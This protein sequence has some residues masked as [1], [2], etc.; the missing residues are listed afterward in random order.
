MADFPKQKE[1]RDSRL[2]FAKA[3]LILLVI[4]GHS[5][6]VLELENSRYFDLWIYKFIYSFHMPAFM[7]ISGY[8]FFQSNT[9][10]LKTVILTKIKS[11]GIPFLSFTCLM[12]FLG[13]I[14]DLFSLD[15]ITINSFPQLLEDLFDYILTSKVMWF[16]ASILINS[17]IASCLSRLKVGYVGFI[18]IIII[19][20]FIPVENPY[21][22][23]AY[24]FMF[25]YF[26]FGYY[27]KKKHLSLFALQRKYLIIIILF[28]LSIIGLCLYNRDTY[29]YRTGMY[30]LTNKPLYSLYQSFL[31]FA[32]GFSMS[33]LFF[34]AVAHFAHY[35]RS[36]IIKKHLVRVGVITL[37]IYGFQQILIGV[38][39]QSLSILNVKLPSSN[40]VAFFIAAMVMAIS[41]T[42]TIFCSKQKLLSLAFFGNYKENRKH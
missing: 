38:I 7:M 4:L 26:I 21:I 22:A 14:K 20:F 27:L 17:L 34:T 24:L 33:A 41:F 11:I 12:F 37:G 1:A 8:L 6:Q 30:I 39:I 9:K 31:R 10:A 32:L 5:F 23:P 16:L 42:L 28:I 3:F 40:F 36:S 2:D 15:Y 29:I 25:P 19:S 18:F 13:R 35:N